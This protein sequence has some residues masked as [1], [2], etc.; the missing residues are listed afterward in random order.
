MTQQELLQPRYKVIAEDTSAKFRL[1]QII[2]HPD[3]WH[4][5][6]WC[7]NNERENII[8][9]P[10]K[11]PH[12][13]QKLEWWEERHADE[14]PKYLKDTKS[15]EVYELLTYIPPYA[16]GQASDYRVRVHFNHLEPATGEDYKNQFHPSIEQLLQPR[17]K[18][19]ADYPGNVQPIGHIHQCIGDQESIRYWAEQKE[20]YPQVFQRLEWWEHRTDSELPRYM[21]YADDPDTV[22]MFLATRKDTPEKAYMRDA[23]NHEGWEHLKNLFP[24]TEEEYINQPRYRG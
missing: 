17:Y 22:F 13:F 20:K 9:N 15:K 11:Y 16:I 21:K 6:I 3:G 24:A 18:V 4:D 10:E 2:Y 12:L 14:M 8:F 19:I 7:V 23:E 1:N 5:Y